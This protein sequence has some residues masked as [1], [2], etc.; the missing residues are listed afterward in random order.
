MKEINITDRL[1]YLAEQFDVFDSSESSMV[2]AK[3]AEL[4]DDN[5]TTRVIYD[6]LIINP[7][8]GSVKVLVLYSFKENDK[9]RLL[10]KVSISSDVLSSMIS[11]DPTYNKIYLQW[12]LNIFSYF[13]KENTD[14]SLFNGIRLVMEDLPQANKYLTLFEANKRKKKFYNLCKNSYS[15]LHVKDP[16]NINQYKSLAQ[17]FDA[18]DPFIE[19]EPSA[20][21]RTLNR[22]VAAGEAFIPVK[23][24]KFTL[25][26]P[27]TTDASVV[28]AE[29]AN[30]CTARVGN[31][32]FNSYTN[33]NKK[34]NGKNSDIYII[35]NNDFFT[36]KSKEMYQIHFET[37]QVKD[38]KNGQ[39]VSIF[40]G[41][42]AE[43]DGLSN[44]FNKE[45]MEMAKD[46]KRG[47]ENNVY[48]DYLVQ[49]GF[50][51]SLF[52][53]ID[54]RT[55]TIRFMTK[56]IPRLPDMSR[57]KMLDQMVI[58]NAKLVELH[59]SIGSLTNLEM[60]VLTN[61]RINTLPKEIGS[62]TKLTF[63]NLIG[64]PITT[65]PNE[66]KYLDSS[67]GGSLYRLAISVDD[68]GEENY[69]KLKELLPTTQIN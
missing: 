61:N 29:F 55:P 47:F 66:I 10:K 21:E 56:E 3:V 1:E 30:W 23:D 62:L 49:F 7:K 6:S 44:F 18:V 5:Y 36:G 20:L 33:N 11:A 39:N 53:I 67:N 54:E 40:E 68:I 31:G 17:L 60:L 34:P 48:L 50:A 25:Y 12:M 4:S 58:T 26:I 51:D 57:F 14:T 32:M 15:L 13:I 64:N 19:K 2:D 22:F 27:K 9:G 43:S 69:Q 41:V 37:R 59:P 46:N 8:M 45:L 38:Y 63:M 52:E 16:T 42:L 28:F 35:I 65:I 24:R